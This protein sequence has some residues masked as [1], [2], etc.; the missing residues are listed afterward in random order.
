MSDDEPVVVDAVAHAYDLRPTNYAD[1]LAEPFVHG[2]LGFHNLLTPPG[3]YRQPEFASTHD[4]SAEDIANVYA[5]ETDVD[6]VVYHGLLLDDYFYDGLSA[7][8]KGVQMRE[9]HPE[10]VLLYGP[11]NPLDLDRTLEQIDYYAEIGVSGLKVYPARYHNGTTLPVQ[12]NDQTWAVPVIERAL[13]CGIRTIAVHKAMPFGGTESKHYR[14]DDIDFIAL[15]YPEMNFEIVHAGFAFLEDTFMQLGRFANVYANLE[16]TASLAVVRPRRFAEIL[17]N[18]LYVG[19]E[20]RILFA[21]GFCVAHPQPAIDAIRAF[22]MPEDMLADGMP[23]ITNEAKSKILGRN[24]L[25]LHGIDER[26]F[27]RR[28][29]GDAWSLQRAQ[30]AAEP[31]HVLRRG[32]GV[33]A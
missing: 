9:L 5:R 17:G 6:L 31:Y 27:R 26:D 32:S 15:R 24:L 13:A 29:D 22:E 3:P 10:R 4:W 30:G 33:A 14:V 8:S 1:P 23:E 28:T 20:D 19:G 12:F 21:S 16:C 7:F 18:M 25:G 11:I 2:V